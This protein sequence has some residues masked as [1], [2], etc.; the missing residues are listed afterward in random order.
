MMQGFPISAKLPEDLGFGER[1]WYWRGISGQSYIHSIY[2][3]E[4]CPPLPGAVF[5]VVRQVEGRRCPLAVGR[6]PAAFEG[7]SFDIAAY[8][9]VI[10]RG[11]EIHVHLL[12]RDNDG[13]S[14]VQS[15]LQQALSE[16]AEAEK[17]APSG[18]AEP[19]QLVLI[20][21]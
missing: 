12:A 15:D 9:P 8:A 4:A 2:S 11:D 20:A 19:A 5:V 16:P 14:R 7:R 1:F 13:A 10:R 18:F 6:F 3:R 21:A 17:V